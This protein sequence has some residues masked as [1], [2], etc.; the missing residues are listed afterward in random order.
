M[1]RRP[2]GRP[3]W[4]PEDAEGDA[5]SGA[6]DGR[7]SGWWG[8]RR[9]GD[10]RRGFG[11]LIALMSTL[12]VSIGVLILWLLAGLLGVASMEGP[13]AY[14]A[15]PAGLIVLVVGIVALIIGIRIA[16]GVGQPLSE[17]VD[18]AGRID[19]V[20]GDFLPAMR[21]QAMHNHGL[22]RRLSK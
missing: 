6:P 14:L 18:A 11:C 1:T 8:P 20:A 16:R 2:H 3:P 22:R 17:L 7:A 4:W 19:G 9:R 10:V 5:G 21:G 15:R 12:V 13:L